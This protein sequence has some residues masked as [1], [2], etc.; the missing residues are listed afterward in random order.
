MKRFFIGITSFVFLLTYVVFFQNGIAFN[1]YL[2][3]KTSVLDVDSFDNV[4]NLNYEDK[5][6]ELNII[7]HP[8]TEYTSSSEIVP[9]KTLEYCESLVYRTLK[10]LPERSVKHLKHL[11]LYFADKGRR[12]LGGGDTVI[13]RCQNVSDDEL[14][15]VLVHEMGHVTDT[16]VLVGHTSKGRSEF[17]D[18]VNPVYNDDPSLGF[19]RISFI[20][21][22]SLKKDA[23]SLDFVSGY[24][25]TDPFEDFAE[26]YNFYILHGPT[27]REM[28]KYNDVLRQK[29]D[30][31]KGVALDGFFKI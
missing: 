6:K 14:V 29:Y 26:S 7:L 28:A 3:G 13:L 11:T 30:F 5:F 8:G 23:S 22:K 17:N 25:M 2:E 1:Y 15:S 18:G 9:S 16:G 20:N 10:S 21:E 24:A 27:F 4:A 12:G 31:L 19:Y